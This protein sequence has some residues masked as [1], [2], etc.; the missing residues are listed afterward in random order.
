[1]LNNRQ[2]SL[3]T[4][5]KRIARM[6]KPVVSW[7]WSVLVMAALLPSVLLG[8]GCESTPESAQS[9]QVLYVQ[10]RDEVSPQDL[11]VSIG[12]EIRWQNLRSE[13]VKIGLLDTDE[14]EDAACARGFKRFGLLDNFA[15]IPPNDYVSLCVSHRG[16]IQYNV[17]M[18]PDDMLHSM[19]RTATI[20]IDRTS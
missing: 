2:Q 7:W 3:D 1:M 11:H 4:E 14:L 10:I 19:T 16:T 20:H 9:G 18:D 13:P 17:W 5:S 6:T 15:I 8:S 12:D